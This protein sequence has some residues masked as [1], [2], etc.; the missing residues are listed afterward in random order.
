MSAFAGKLKTMIITLVQ[1]MNETKVNHD[2]I[3]VCS[4]NKRQNL[5]RL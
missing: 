2:E 3:E 1:R 5:S 4:I